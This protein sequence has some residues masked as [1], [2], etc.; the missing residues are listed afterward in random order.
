MFKPTKRLI[1]FI[2][3]LL[4]CLTFT[5]ACHNPAEDDSSVEPSSTEQSSDK[6]EGEKDNNSGES[7]NGENETPRIPFE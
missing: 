4:V 3:S 7:G 5:V 2:L 1:V 6:Q